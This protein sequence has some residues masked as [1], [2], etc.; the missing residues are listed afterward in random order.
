MV[1]MVIVF[2]PILVYAVLLLLS[3]LNGGVSNVGS[4]NRLQIRNDEN[5]DDL[6]HQTN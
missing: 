4:E 2:Y 5:I 1:A 3:L 6:T